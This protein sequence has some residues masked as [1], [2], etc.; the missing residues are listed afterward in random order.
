MRVDRPTICPLKLKARP[1][2]SVD[3]EEWYHTCLVPD[4]VRPHR[5]PVLPTELDWLIPEI[6]ELFE[7]FGSRATFF[8]LGEVAEQVPH[9]IRQIVDM[10][11]EIASHG[12]HHLRVGEL[13]AVEFR[14][15]V[16]RAKTQ[17]EQ[18]SGQRVL[19]YR[20]P[21][22]SLR[23]V[24]NPKLK[25]LVEE[26]YLYDSSLAPYLL[27][28]SLSNPRFPCRLKWSTALGTTSLLE[29]PPMTYGGRLRVPA[30]GWTGRLLSGA[31]IANRLDRAVHRGESPLVVVHPWELSNRP[32]PGHLRGLAGFVHEAGRAGY[33][34]KFAELLGRQRFWPVRDLL[35]EQ[36]N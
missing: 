33:G 5:R 31:W 7:S 29:V 6:L 22:W 20:S 23:R 28:G 36:I 16:R 34:T 18:L 14:E 9:R 1:G 21:E 15:D 35:G 12:F 4:Y 2:L 25:I 24:D 3:V 11:H 13:D 26:G 27:A 8:T 17:L 10:G 19:G 30:A 32:T